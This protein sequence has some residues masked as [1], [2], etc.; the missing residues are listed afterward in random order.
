MGLLASGEKIQMHYCD[1]TQW[2]NVNPIITVLQ[3]APLHFL[4]LTAMLLVSSYTGRK[5]P[6][7]RKMQV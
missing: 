4:C 1:M 7:V 6:D 5:R 2:I 3:P